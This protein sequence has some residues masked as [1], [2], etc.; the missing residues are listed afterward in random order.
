MHSIP[1]PGFPVLIAP[2]GADRVQE[3]VDANSAMRPGDAEIK[4][5][6]GLWHEAVA[7]TRLILAAWKNDALCGHVTMKWQS[8]YDGFRRKNAPEIVD[9]WVMP[10]HRRGKIGMAL[11]EHAM[12]RARHARAAY[13]GLCVGVSDN[14]APA[15]TLYARLGFRP[16]GSGLWRGGDKIDA[17]ESGIDIDDDTVM[18]WIK[19]L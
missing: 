19:P 5:L 10:D 1:S 12:D 11:M 17:R 2:L 14:F 18:M 15:R 9:L 3:W 4:R 13:V 16:D 6:S 7:G 8:D